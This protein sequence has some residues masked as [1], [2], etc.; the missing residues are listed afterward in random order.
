MQVKTQGTIVLS[1][2]LIP[3]IL[4][5]GIGLLFIY[6]LPSLAHLLRFPFY[7]LEP[8]RIILILAIAHTTKR[9]SIA[10][11]ATLPF[12]S[13][14]VS[15]HPE[16]LKSVV[17]SFELT[18]NVFS[19]YWLNGKM[20]NIFLT[21]WVSISSSKLLCYLLYILFFS[22]RFV[23]E[24]ASFGLLFVQFCITFALSLYVQVIM[25]KINASISN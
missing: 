16:L 23:I 8:M 1:R 10:L 15:G 22:W 9:N 4:F 21:M 11:A 7:L 13:F 25:K 3:Q 12:F 2:N 24:E 20:R 14:L 18:F 6:L 5:D 17:I 19:F